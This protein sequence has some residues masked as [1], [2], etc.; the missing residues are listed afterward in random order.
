MTSKAILALKVWL[1]D[2]GSSSHYTTE[3]LWDIGKRPSHYL[4]YNFFFIYKAE[5]IIEGYLREWYERQ[6][7]KRINTFSILS[8]SPS[9]AS[10]LYGNWLR[11]KLNNS[12]FRVLQ[13]LTH[14]Y[15]PYLCN[16]IFYILKLNV[17]LCLCPCILCIWDN[18]PFESKMLYHTITGNWK[19]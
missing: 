1:W 16:P 10:P 13:R 12:R 8:D 7:G 4:V 11:M 18:V 3:L 14:P 2:V 19:V 5:I 17:P 15:L 6:I 9:S